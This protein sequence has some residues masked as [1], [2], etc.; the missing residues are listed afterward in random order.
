MDDA[1]F[2][3]RAE[4]MSALGWSLSEKALAVRMTRVGFTKRVKEARAAIRDALA[5]NPQGDDPTPQQIADRAA[6]IRVANGA[7]LVPNLD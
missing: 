1:Q 3:A 5:M 4:A 6:A 2:L 7:P